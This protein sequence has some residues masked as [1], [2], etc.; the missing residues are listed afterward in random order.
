VKSQLKEY[1]INLDVR[2]SSWH[3]IYIMLILHNRPSGL[4]LIY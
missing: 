1:T 2:L 4:G 3:F